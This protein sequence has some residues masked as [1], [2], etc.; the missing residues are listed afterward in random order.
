[1]IVTGIAGTDPSTDKAGP[2][3]LTDFSDHPFA[4]RRAKLFRMPDIPA[5]PILG[6]RPV[7]NPRPL[8]RGLQKSKLHLP[9]FSPLS[10]DLV[11][12]QQLKERKSIAPILA[13]NIEAA[14]H[15][16]N[17]I[18]ASFPGNSYAPG[19]QVDG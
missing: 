12:I 6:S 19:R 4:H 9:D 11:A 18:W 2:E 8:L 14:I 1:M 5:P 16:C 17:A 3:I 10:Q 13:G 7:P 15:L